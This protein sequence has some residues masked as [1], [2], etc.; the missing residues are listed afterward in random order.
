MSTVWH[1]IE[2]GTVSAQLISPWPHTTRAFKWPDFP[3]LTFHLLGL[4]A[5]VAME[6]Y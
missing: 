3:T 2:D 6:M 1:R 4:S 5:S